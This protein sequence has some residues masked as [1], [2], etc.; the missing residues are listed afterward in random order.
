MYALAIKVRVGLAWGFGTVMINCPE[1]VRW[2]TS[3]EGSMLFIL[4]V[5]LK[6][7][8]PWISII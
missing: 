4:Q 7:T 8:L 6:W 5:S 1:I 2:S 3:S